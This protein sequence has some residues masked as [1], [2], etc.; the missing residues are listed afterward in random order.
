MDAPAA[1]TIVI[2]EDDQDL[3]FMYKLK[4]ERT[5]Y[6]VFTAGDGAAGLRIIEQRRPDLILLDLMMPRMSGT[7]MLARL[8]QQTWAADIRVVVLTNVSKTEAPSALRFLGVDRYVIKA[9]HTPAQIVDLVAELLGQAHRRT[10]SQYSG[11]PQ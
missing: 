9:H 7:E 11:S 1:A 8:R 3:Q 10:A 2:V 6:A 5:G 4:L